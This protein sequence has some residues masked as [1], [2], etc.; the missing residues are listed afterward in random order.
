VM[1]E[2][3][4]ESLLTVAHLPH[5][6]HPRADSGDGESPVAQLETRRDHD[7]RKLQSE[8]AKNGGNVALAARAAGLSRQR[9]YRILSIVKQSG[10]PDADAR[11]DKSGAT[12]GAGT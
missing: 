10:A 1:A 7:L 5:E 3:P 6:F 2:W 8:L 12:S 4:L 11:T 9:A